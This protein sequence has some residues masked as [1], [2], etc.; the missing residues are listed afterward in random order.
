[1]ALPSSGVGIPIA[2]ALAAG[3]DHTCAALGDGRLRC[4]GA[5]D[6]GQLGD[7]RVLDPGVGT[8]VSPLGR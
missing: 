8:L 5:D 3:G 2:R 6:R 7:D 1:V 4:W